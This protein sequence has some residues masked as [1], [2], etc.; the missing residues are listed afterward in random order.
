MSHILVTFNDAPANPA[1]LKYT[2]LGPLAIK[3][4]QDYGA[5][6]DI[7]VAI[8]SARRSDIPACWNKLPDILDLLKL[9]DQVTWVDSDALAIDLTRPMSWL[10]TP[11]ADFIA[12]CP[13]QFLGHIE[14][15]SG[16]RQKTMPFNAGVFTVRSTKR[17]RQC[18]EAAWK[19]RPAPD[20]A[21]PVWNGLG[22]EEALLKA[23]AQ[24]QPDIALMPDMQ[25]HPQHPTTDTV[26]AHFY[27]N[28][29][30]P[31]LDT[32]QQRAQIALW[33][34]AIINKQPLPENPAA[35]H[36]AMIQCPRGAAQQ[37]IP[38]RTPDRFCYAVEDIMSCTAH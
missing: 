6:H 36:W 35:F 2:E 7:P 17:A 32:A 29:G 19:A 28:H 31:V 20:A 4:L 10:D 26:F 24:H 38:L 34:A 22:D 15:S 1:S 13:Q 16:A 5:A 30:V 14:M 18:L 3:R 37:D 9:Y 11:D 25:S 27:G 12:Q 23:F 8:T 21:S 33:R